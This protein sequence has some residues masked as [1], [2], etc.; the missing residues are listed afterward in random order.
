MLADQLSDQVG[1]LRS[2]PDDQNAGEPPPPVVCMPSRRPWAPL[3]LVIGEPAPAADLITRL[4]FKHLERNLAAQTAPKAHFR[5]IWPRQRRNCQFCSRTKFSTQT[6]DTSQIGA[7]VAK[8]GV[9]P[10]TMAP[11]A[12]VL[13]V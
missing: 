2:P 10:G 3:H 11:P 8:E 1:C 5:L 6:W 12:L 9:N 7:P 13:E 4:I